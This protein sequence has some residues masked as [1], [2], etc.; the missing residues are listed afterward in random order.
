MLPERYLSVHDFSLRKLLNKFIDFSTGLI[1]HQREATEL[2]LTLHFQIV[3]IRF[4]YRMSQ[5]ERSILWEVIVLVILSKKVYIVTCKGLAWLII[6]GSGF[7][8]WVYWQF[9][10]V[11][12]NYNGSH[13]E[14]LLNDVCLTN[15]V[16]RISKWSLNHL[17]SLIY[18]LLYPPRGPNICY[19]VE[20]LIAL[21]YSVCCHWNVFVNI[22]C[23]G[24]RCLRAVA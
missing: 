11:T 9:F 3:R 6:M 17:K 23:R 18:S 7:C 1:R 8:D 14:L 2:T 19:H 21:C 24:N 22:R 16:W 4:T 20:Q 15:P 13:I 10:T 12:V 5:E